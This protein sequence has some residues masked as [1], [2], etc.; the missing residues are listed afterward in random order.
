MIVLCVNTHRIHVINKRATPNEI[1]IYKLAIQL[2]KLYNTPLPTREWSYLNQ[3]QFFTSRQTTFMS[4]K[5]NTY[6]VGLNALANR[7]TSL[8]G[9]IPL[10]WLNLS[11]QSYKIKCKNLLLKG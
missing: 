1:T 10:E 2:F 5:T 9:K 4:H 11:Y 7:L 8:N 6:K 3:N